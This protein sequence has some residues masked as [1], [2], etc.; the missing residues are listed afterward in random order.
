MAQVKPQATP[1]DPQPSAPA[2]NL[3]SN[4]LN[5]VADAPPIVGTPIALDESITPNPGTG[6]LSVNDAPANDWIQVGV[7][8]EPS[9]AAPPED[10]LVI[11]GSDLKSLLST[12]ARA[13]ETGNLQKLV[14]TFATDIY[15][16]DGASREQMER[17][18][19]HLFNITDNRQLTIRDITW[20]QQD[21]QMLGSGDFQVRIREKGASK[22]TT[23]AGKISL[24]V[25]KESNNIV[26]RK[27]DYD[28]NN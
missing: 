19:R 8:N 22:Y 6:N 28:Y 4:E 27:L 9:V 12:L 14:S 11:S 7:R 17:D 23:Y 5:L 13:Y 20:S 10:N 15:S 24:A 25:V 26:I 3:A 21:K 1:S 2:T 18:Y 16:S